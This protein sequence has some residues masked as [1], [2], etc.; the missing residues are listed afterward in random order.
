M[1]DKQIKE[2]MRL[3]KGLRSLRILYPC[4]AGIPLWFGILLLI[5]SD[6]KSS[7][8]AIGYTLLVLGIFLAVLCLILYPIGYFGIR[9]QFIDGKIDKY[10]NRLTVNKPQTVQS[11]PARQQRTV[12]QQPVRQPSASSTKR[13]A[14]K[15][16]SAE[17][18]SINVDDVLDNPFAKF[19]TAYA[20]GKASQEATKAM[21]IQILESNAARY[22][23][24]PNGQTPGS[25]AMNKFSN[26]STRKVGKN[27]EITTMPNGNENLIDTTKGIKVA[28]YDKMKDE[29]YV[30]LKR[31]GKG[32]QLMSLI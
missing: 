2:A 14:T 23:D 22:R 20:V 9:Q 6:K 32:N 25:R 1:S 31:V 4:L 28:Y 15:R 10:G 16:D 27:Y 17:S 13:N 21:G 19:A 30:G 18:S 7:M 11:K 26:M 8:E 5:F 3:N 24:L 29:T 12:T